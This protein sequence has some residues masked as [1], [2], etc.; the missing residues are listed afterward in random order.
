METQTGEWT[1]ERHNDGVEILHSL[2]VPERPTRLVRWCVPERSALVLGSAQPESDVDVE[3]MSR[4]GVDLVR[5]RSGGGAVLVEPEDVVWVDVVIP[6]NDQLWNDDVGKAFNWLG[7]V[8]LRALDALNIEDV[9]AHVGALITNEWS[10]KICFAGLGPG[11]IVQKNRKIIGIS[12][13]RTRAGALFQCAFLKNM[14]AE[15][16]TSLLNMSREQQTQATRY[17][18][19][20]TLA[21]PETD[22]SKLEQA[23]IQALP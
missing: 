20:T 23:F 1:I 22:E 10:R 11:E 15:K 19:E 14:R 12:Q 13:R 6:A 17:L 21:L 4:Q 8:W 9:H 7:D 18:Q 16:L 5:R 2:G 3:A